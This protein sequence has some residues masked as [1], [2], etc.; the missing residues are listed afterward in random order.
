MR[1]PDQKLIT[2]DGWQQISAEISRGTARVAQRICSQNFTQCPS[3]QARVSSAQQ[4]VLSLPVSLLVHKT[5][6]PYRLGLE[7][8]KE[9]KWLGWKTGQEHG[10]TLSLKNVSSDVL[11]L[12][13]SMPASKLFVLEYP[14]P[15][16][17]SPGMS[18]NLKVQHASRTQRF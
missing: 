17:L 15:I 5:A 1:P 2:T 12:R 4:L 8:C 14:E 16:D 3:Q 18:Y 13:W 11:H 10:R 6:R 9:I 7:C